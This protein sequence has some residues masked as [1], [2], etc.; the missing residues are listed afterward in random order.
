MNRLCYFLLVSTGVFLV[1][2][3]PTFGQSKGQKINPADLLSFQVAVSAADPF[4]ESNRAGKKLLV[5]RGEL[6]RLQI[7]G[8]PREGFHTYPVTK[9][10]SAQETSALTRLKYG[11]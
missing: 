7:T 1:Y 4:D 3:A 5:R 6:V 8:I 11:D 2:I 9:R 10:S